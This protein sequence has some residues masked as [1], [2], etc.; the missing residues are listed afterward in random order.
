VN[1][2][3]ELMAYQLFFNQNDSDKYDESYPVFNAYSKLIT[4]IDMIIIDN[5][6]TIEYFRCIYILNLFAI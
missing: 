3:F 5:I 4:S 6:I 2:L 1:E